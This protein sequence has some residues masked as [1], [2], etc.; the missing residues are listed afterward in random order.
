MGYRASILLFINK[1]TGDFVIQELGKHRSLGLGT[2]AGPLIY[3]QKS[4]VERNG[5]PVSKPKL[6]KSRMVEPHEREGLSAMTPAEGAAFKMKHFE[7]SVSLTDED[8]GMVELM[9]MHEYRKGRR[10][11]AVGEYDVRIEIPFRASS[12]RFQ[13]ALRDIIERCACGT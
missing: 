5:W 4:E 13:T 12:E 6:K 9:I 8:E 11:G 3:L 7:I 10:C 1:E 2:P